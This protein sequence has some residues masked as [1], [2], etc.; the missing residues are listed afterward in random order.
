M[1]WAVF[2]SL[3]CICNCCVLAGYWWYLLEAEAPF[4]TVALATA[5]L[6]SNFVTTFWLLFS[7]P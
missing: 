2:F 3:T 7:E 1:K 5:W 6:L 4:K